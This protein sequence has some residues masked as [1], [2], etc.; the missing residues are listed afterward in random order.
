M[1]EAWMLLIPSY[2]SRAALG[3]CLLTLTLPSFAQSVADVARQ[4]RERQKAANSK[5]VITGIGAQPSIPEE[6]EAKTAQ[7][8]DATSGTSAAPKKSGVTDNK[9][10][11][12]K[13]WRG[14]FQKAREDAKRADSRV[15]VLD[16][17]VK[18]LNTKLLRQ[19]D[20]YNREY[21]LGTEITSVQ[22]E[23]DDARKEAEQAGK[24][25]TDLEDELRKSGGPAG[26]A[27]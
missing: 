16:L 20:I 12:E 6:S 22:K 26:W 1:K 8:A 21:R 19:S 11:D 7:A 18:E 24:K 4:E 10:R 15:E 23:L 5:T 3:V 14:A 27:R 17:K 9:G 25:I 2:M 13:Y